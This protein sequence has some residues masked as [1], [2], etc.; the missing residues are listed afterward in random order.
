[1]RGTPVADEIELDDQELRAAMLEAANG[2]APLGEDLARRLDRWLAET[3]GERVNGDE[4]RFISPDALGM[5]IAWDE[6]ADVP[7][8]LALP[9]D[10]FLAAVREAWEMA[11][12]DDVE[13]NLPGACLYG[14]AG[15]DGREAWL[16]NEWGGGYIASGPDQSSGGLYPTADE[17]AGALF[18][19]GF[20]RS[21]DIGPADLPEIR[22]AI[23]TWHEPST[24]DEDEDRDEA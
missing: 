17:A 19:L 14:I 11:F 21:Q 3:W 5:H 20:F 12:D 9:D 4:C 7:A 6:D 8:L 10:A 16:V 1:M 24:R 13:M 2:G 15:D 18:G 22:A 23:E